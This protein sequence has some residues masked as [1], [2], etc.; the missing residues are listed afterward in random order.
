MN[1]RVRLLFAAV[2]AVMLFSVMTAAAQPLL[3]NPPCGTLRVKNLTATPVTITMIT[4]PA[5]AI[6]TLV[7][8]PMF[9]SPTVP[10][11]FGTTINAVISAAGFA[12]P[13]VQPAP[14]SPPAPIAGAGW[15]PGI[16]V[17]GP[18]PFCADIYFD[19]FNC[20]VY[21]VAPGT[22]PCRP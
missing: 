17:Q 2:C 9:E 12:Y 20:T 21:V 22:A 19:T 14:P 7:A 18:P 11:P 5:G 4:T 16:F 3:W 10:V 6:P 15:I 8:P 13:M 1:A